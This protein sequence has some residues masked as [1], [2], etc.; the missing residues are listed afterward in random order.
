MPYSAVMYNGEEGKKTFHKV[1]I[2]HLLKFG[3][4]DLVNEINK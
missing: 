4:D 1:A 3:S 2:M